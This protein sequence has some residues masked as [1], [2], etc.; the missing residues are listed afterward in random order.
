MNLILFAIVLQFLVMWKDLMHDSDNN[1][2]NL[3]GFSSCSYILRVSEVF[4]LCLMY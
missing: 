4:L 3:Y 2:I 1:C